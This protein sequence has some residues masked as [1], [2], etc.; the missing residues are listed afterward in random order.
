MSLLG[1]QAYNL[2]V[3]ND[4]PNIR[5]APALRKKIIGLLKREFEA[6][7]KTP[8]TIMDLGSGNGLMTRE[9]AKALPQA[10]VIGIERTKH[11]FFWANWFKRREKLDNLAYKNMNFLKAD[12]SEA[13]AIYTYMMPHVLYHLSK[14]LDAE[15]KPGTL[16]ITNK[17]ALGEGWK[18]VETLRLKTL[19]FH[20][21]NLLVYRKA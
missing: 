11:T 18:P 14:K 16:I 2:M 13:D 19:Y 21:G 12:L 15:L 4:V 17:F 10:N 5:T 3:H 20:Q 8:F 9:I 1:L 7:K 6:R